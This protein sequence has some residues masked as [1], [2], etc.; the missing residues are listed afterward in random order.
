MGGKITSGKNLPYEPENTEY[1]DVGPITIGVGYRV[2]NEK[3]VIEAHGAEHLAASKAR[4][5][6][7]EDSG[8]AIH[9]F[10]GSGGE[11]TERLRF[12]CFA[13]G[14]HYHYITP[15][16]DIQEIWE[17]DTVAD[18]EALTWVLERLKS[19]LPQLLSHAGATKLAG[20]VDQAEIEAAMPK[21]AEAAQ[22]AM[23]R[24]Q[25]A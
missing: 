24:G 12:D 15:E 17:M 22:K 5:D 19:R 10:E 11:L 4:G 25:P 16:R 3:V 20:R 13:K 21:V 9:V 1:I 2:V 23:E 8:V 14:P 7:Q 18:G 6:F